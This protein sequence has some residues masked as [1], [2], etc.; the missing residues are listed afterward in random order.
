MPSWTAE[1]GRR[2]RKDLRNGSLVVPWY[3][4]YHLFVHSSGKRRKLLAL[5]LVLLPVL[6]VLLALAFVLFAE[7]APVFPFVFAAEG[8]LP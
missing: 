4:C 2:S 5:S 3:G 6:A 8:S 7:S 1:K